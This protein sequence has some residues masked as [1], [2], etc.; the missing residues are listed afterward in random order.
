M[1]IEEGYFSFGAEKVKYVPKGASSWKHRAVGT[2]K[3]TDHTNEIFKYKQ[4]FPK[5]NWKMFHDA[6]QAHRF[7]VLH[8]ILPRYEI[9]AA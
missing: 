6:L 7:T 1:R 9:I 5:S 3:F 2:K 4:T 8:D